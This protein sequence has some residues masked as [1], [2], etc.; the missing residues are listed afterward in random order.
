[1]PRFILFSLYRPE[2]N[3]NGHMVFALKII[4]H[5]PRALAHA[6]SAEPKITCGSE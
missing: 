3:V 5:S 1:M 4:R 2:V 6:A